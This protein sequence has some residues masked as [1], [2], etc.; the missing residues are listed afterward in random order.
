MS[1]IDRYLVRPH[2]V[3]LKALGQAEKKAD[4]LQKKLHHSWLEDYF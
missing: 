4:L 2:M 3:L 1:S